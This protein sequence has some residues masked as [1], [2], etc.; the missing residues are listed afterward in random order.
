MNSLDLKRIFHLPH[1]GVAGNAFAGLKT[2][3]E[4]STRQRL[5]PW[6]RM[7]WFGAELQGIKFRTVWRGT[8]TC[9]DAG[10]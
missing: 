3:G 9:H 6:N 2:Q 7:R 8:F 10:R 1:L 5:G 4:Q